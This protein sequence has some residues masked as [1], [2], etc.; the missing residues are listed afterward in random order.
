MVFTLAVVVLAGCPQTEIVATVTVTQLRL[1]GTVIQ[2]ECARSGDLTCAPADDCTHVSIIAIVEFSSALPRVPAPT[3]EG[4]SNRTD[5][6]DE[7]MGVEESKD[8]PVPAL[9][10]L[11]RLR[12]EATSASAVAKV[13]Q[14]QL[15]RRTRYAS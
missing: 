5:D 6:A 13:A 1:D 3:S 8:D 2:S 11:H 9:I 10:S 12:C 7:I 15:L 14:T 4:H